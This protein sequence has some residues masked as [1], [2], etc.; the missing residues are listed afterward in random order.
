MLVKAS[1]C[2]KVGGSIPFP[3]VDQNACRTTSM[4]P[5]GVSV[6]LMVLQ[7]LVWSLKDARMLFGLHLVEMALGP[8]LTILV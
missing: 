1:V 7:N 2:L 8:V 5:L 6:I 4:R 3:A